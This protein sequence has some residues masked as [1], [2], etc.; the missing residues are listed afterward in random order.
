MSDTSELFAPVLLASYNFSP[1]SHIIDIGGGHGSLL[2]HI[3]TKHTSLKAT[4]FDS[5]Q[6]VERAMAN[7]SSFNLTERI[8]IK[9]GNFFEEVP[10]G[11]NLYILKNILHDWDDENNIKILKN[12]GKAMLP[13]SKL[14]II[15]CIITDDNEYSYGK[16]LDILMLIGTQDGRER[17]L[18]E[19]RNI[20]QKSGFELSRVIPTIS[21][22]SL[23]ECAKQSES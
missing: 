1:F 23:I 9:A 18:G 4:L 16:M 2:C 12:I 20:I 6:V 14:L 19:F 22:F 3:L 21:P 15:E 10:E 17:T 5:L 13:G 11:G 8:K 7:I